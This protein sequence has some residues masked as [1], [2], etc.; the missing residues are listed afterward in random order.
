VRWMAKRNGGVFEAEQRLWLIFPTAFIFP[1]GIWIFGIGSNDGWSWPAPYVGLGFIGFGW[2]CAGDLSMAYLMDAYP[3]M[4]LEGMVGVS[5]INNTIGMVFS[6]G[7]SRWLAAESVQS[8]F[9]AIGV[10]AFVFMMTT[11]PM[12]IWGKACRRWTR[13]RYEQF[14]LLRDGL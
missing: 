5:V 7:A 2:G 6:F 14:L 1:I 9:I 4:V 12:I 3:E 13:G 11:V 10:L 8:V